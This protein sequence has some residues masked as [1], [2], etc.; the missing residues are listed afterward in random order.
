V[1]IGLVDDPNHHITLIAKFGKDNQSISE[2]SYYFR[3]KP[4]L[5]RK[6]IIFAN[7]SDAVKW[8]GNKYLRVRLTN[9]GSIILSSE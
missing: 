5:I 1:G 6:A 7:N 3:V 4:S 2:E 8:A 9:T